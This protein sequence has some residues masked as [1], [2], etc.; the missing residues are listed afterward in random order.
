MLVSLALF[1]VV[2]F[3]VAGI[4]ANPSFQRL[5]WRSANVACL[6]SIA[7]FVIEFSR[8]TQ[9]WPIAIPLPMHTEFLA[10]LYFVGHVLFA[11]TPIAAFSLG[12]DL[13]AHF[14]DRGFLAD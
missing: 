3:F 11:F 2:C 4:G 7:W 5:V 14:N 9:A 10:A 8:A 12:Q 6:S 1:S 13:D